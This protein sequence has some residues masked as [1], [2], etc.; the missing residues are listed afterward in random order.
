[1]PE[2]TVQI[3]IRLLL[4]EQFDW[5]LYCLQVHILH[6]HHENMLIYNFDPLKPHLYTL[7]LWFTGI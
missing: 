6:M 7:K 5:E 4:K 2:Q 3:E 1:M